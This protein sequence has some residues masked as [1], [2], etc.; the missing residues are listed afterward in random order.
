MSLEFQ[1]DHR[2]RSYSSRISRVKHYV[3][4]QPSYQAQDTTNVQ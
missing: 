2:L 4:M 1:A 3:S